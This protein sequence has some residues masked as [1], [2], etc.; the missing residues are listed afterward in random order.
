[1][2]LRPR[3]AVAV[4]LALASGA[5]AQGPARLFEREEDIR[6]ALSRAQAEGAAARKRAEALEAEAAKATQAAERT[7]RE[8]AGIAARIQ[9]AEARIAAQEARAALIERQRAAQRARLAEQQ[10]PLVELTA[11]LQHLSRRPPVLSLLRPGSVRDAMHM[12]AVLDALLPQ[13]EARTAGLRQEIARG[14]QLQEQAKAAAAELRA[15]Q[16]QLK[17][18]RTALAALESR[19]RIAQRSAGAV[20]DR[21]AERALALAE[22][23]RDLDGLAAAIART[24]ELRTTLAALA[25]PVLRPE[26]PAEAQVT[27]P[28]ETPSAAATGLPAY[29]LPVTGRL[30]T[31]FGE[32]APGQVRS[33]GISLAARSG[34]Q[35]IAPG[36]GRI[37]FAGPWRGFGQIAI[38]EHPGG[39]TSLVAGMA[40]LDARVGDGV[41]AGSPL[42]IAGAGRPV[43]TLELRR[44]GEPVNPLDHVSAP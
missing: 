10:Q 25:G 24:G 33:R 11:A 6:A 12:R 5:A 39:W 41:V 7:A 43:V 1:M 13:V 22:Q 42:G 40:Q 28:V 16:A 4:L 31:G 44:A 15:S 27:V 20:A 37:A 38:V 34:A 23:A 2:L 3:L 21:E 29:L 8:A 30:V 26:R 35:V 32:A 17:A 18:R 14:R 9:Q 19:Q 36:A